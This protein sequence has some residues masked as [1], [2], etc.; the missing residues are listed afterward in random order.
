MSDEHTR[1][2][3]LAMGA[4]TATGV[5]ATLAMT[6]A[7]VGQSKNNNN[8]NNNNNGGNGQNNPAPAPSIGSGIPAA[9]AVGGVLLGMKFWK[10]RQSEGL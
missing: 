10:R 9:L 1:R 8:N 5:V 2:G 3:I 4:T 6:R 7:A